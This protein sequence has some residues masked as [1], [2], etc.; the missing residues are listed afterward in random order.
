MAVCT[1]LAE[2]TPYVVSG[3]VGGAENVILE[4]FAVH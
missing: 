3:D 1:E 4:L 2:V